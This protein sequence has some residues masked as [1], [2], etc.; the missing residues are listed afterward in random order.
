MRIP[1]GGKQA[2]QGLVHPRSDRVWR[3]EAGRGPYQRG[4]RVEQ[5]MTK[6]SS[7][8]GQLSAGPQH[9]GRCRVPEKIGR[10]SGQANR[11]QKFFKAAG[12]NPAMPTWSSPGLEHMRD[13]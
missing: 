7:D 8:G 10:T 1:G 13:R 12:Y 2:K 9:A 6:H 11:M 5:P 4:S 3:L